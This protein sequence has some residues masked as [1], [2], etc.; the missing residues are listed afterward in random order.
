YDELPEQYE[1][2]AAALGELGLAYIHLVSYERVGETLNHA[3]KR[4][5]GGT[6][7]VNGG[8]DRKKAEA[9]L[10]AGLGDLAAFATSFLANPD[11]PHR[12]RHGLPLNAPDSATFYTPGERGYIDYP[13]AQPV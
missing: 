10:A 2:L 11:L 1:R 4:A 13:F 5:F 9:A 7:I 8:L 12:L 6:I 3:M